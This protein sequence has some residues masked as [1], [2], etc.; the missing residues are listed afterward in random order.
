MVSQPMAVGAGDELTVTVAGNLDG[1]RRG[2]EHAVGTPS[3]V[4]AGRL[5]G[6]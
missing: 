5:A 2:S 4:R 6:A 3:A 1:D